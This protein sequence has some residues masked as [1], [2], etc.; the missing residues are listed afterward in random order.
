MAIV[1]SDEYELILKKLTHEWVDADELVD[2]LIYHIPPGRALRQYQQRSKM[3]KGIRFFSDD[4]KHRS[5]AK[6]LLRSALHTGKGSETIM[7]R[8]VDGKLQVRLNKFNAAY[9][10][11]LLQKVRSNDESKK[12]GLGS[13]Q[14]F[15]IP[16]PPPLEMIVV[17]PPAPPPGKNIV[18]RLFH[19]L[20]DHKNIKRDI[21]VRNSAQTGQVIMVIKEVVD[22]QDLT[23]YFSTTAADWLSDQLGFQALIVRGKEN[24]IKALPPRSE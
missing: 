13:G 18:G 14:S 9:I 24:P 22:D 1:R 23:L 21:E 7:H 4:E 20:F 16:P 15:P 5:G 8:V 10:D 12:Q 2:G 3:S 17:S 19:R 11:E 6:S